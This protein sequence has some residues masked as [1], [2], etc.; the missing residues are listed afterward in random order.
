VI[1]A[2]REPVTCCDGLRW[3]GGDGKARFCRS[4]KR[5]VPMIRA[6]EAVGYGAVVFEKAKR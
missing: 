3:Q 2:E 5:I 6:D 1:P 4:E